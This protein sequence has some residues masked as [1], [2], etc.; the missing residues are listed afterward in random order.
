M[1]KRDEEEEGNRNSTSSSSRVCKSKYR[2][3]CIIRRGD[4]EGLYDK[5]RRGGRCVTCAG[6][7][8]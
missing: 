8:C 5:E 3:E 6:C 1:V 7:R 2:I 4:E